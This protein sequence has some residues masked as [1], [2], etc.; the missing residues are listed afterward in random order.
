M[1]D[2][3][4]LATIT[5]LVKDRKS[6]A[7]EINQILTEN[8]HLILARL[9]VNVQRHCIEHCTAMITIAIEA[10]TQEI[11]NITEKIDEFYGIVAKSNILTD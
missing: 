10:T 9:G 2:K 11:N 7:T 6:H 3:K 4:H 5:I 8:G 1:N